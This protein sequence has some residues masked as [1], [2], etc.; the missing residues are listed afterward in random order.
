ML[1]VVQTTISQHS[2]FA[3]SDLLVFLNLV[4]IDVALIQ[5]DPI[6]EVMKEKGLHQENTAQKMHIGRTLEPVS[7]PERAYMIFCILF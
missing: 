3:S 2:E 5:E 4:D 6:E 1:R 7:S